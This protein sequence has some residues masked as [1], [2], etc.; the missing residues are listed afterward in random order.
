M[1]LC[2]NLQNYEKKLF[3]PNSFAQLPKKI[4]LCD[5]KTHQKFITSLLNQRL[6]MKKISFCLLA[7]LCGTVALN[8]CGSDKDEPKVTPELTATYTLTM[9]EDVLNAAN[10]IVYYKGDNGADKFEPVTTTS[11]SKKV[12]TKNFPAQMGF[13]IAVSTKEE[14]SLAKDTYNLAMEGSISGTVNTGGSF[15]NTT[16]IISSQPSVPKS[17]VLNIVEKADGKQMGYRIQKDGSASSV[18]LK[19]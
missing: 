14:S 7:L 9:T 6:T 5:A 15:S 12:T 10:I 11:W 18:S 13:M 19:F 2:S 16:A 3:S 8:S 1:S 4:Y 17:N